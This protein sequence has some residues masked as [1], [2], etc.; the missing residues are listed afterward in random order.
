MWTSSNPALTHDE[1]FEQTYG[2]MTGGAAA[3]PT[4]A[5]VAGVIN[6]TSMPVAIA[7]AA[8]I[9]GYALLPNVPS[10]M[11]ISA[12]AAFGICLG[13][14]FLLAG[15]PQL[16]PVVAPIYAVVEGVFL[17]ALTA[18]LDN[19]LASMEA[20]VPGGLALQAVVI[21]IGLTLAMLVL[22][23]TG[24]IKPT[25]T[26]MAVVGTLAGGVF[27]MYGLMFVLMLFGIQLPF[28]SL[29]S[30]MQG[31]T[32]AWIGLG[33]NVVILII[34]ALTLVIDFKLVE[35][36]VNAGSP[37]YMEWYGG[38]ALLVTIAWIYYEAVKL[39]FRVAMLMRE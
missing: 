36:R 16:S 12:I 20:S 9:A 4:T 34:A 5:T 19:M 32:A 33:I 13:A 27:I 1:T 39:S 10:V 11:W 24:I 2:H 7:A 28:V 29:G 22:Y 17:G 6:K 26:F 31:G 15:K 23:A 38:F 25:K 8:G 18:A 30:A 14:A 3:R 21:T 35:D 37:Q